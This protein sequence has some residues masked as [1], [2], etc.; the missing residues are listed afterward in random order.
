M[1]DISIQ[2]QKEMSSFVIDTYKLLTASLFAATVGAYLGVQ[3]NNVLSPY[4]IPLIIVEFILLFGIM[5]S[6]KIPGLNLFLLFAFTT[7]SGLTLGPILTA[8]LSMSN[9]AEIV[10][11]AFLLTTVAFGSLTMFAMT[12]KTSFLGMGKYLFIALIVVVVAALLNLFFMNSLLSIIISGIS[13][14]LFSFFIVYDTQR[15]YSGEFSSPV[16]A[17]LSMYLN[18]LNLFIALLNILRTFSGRD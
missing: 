3:Y 17:A 6:R 7:V 8:T 14:I 15:I 4:Y 18:I 16:D 12:T 9:G 10:S 11:T 13:A 1:H 2:R 5:F